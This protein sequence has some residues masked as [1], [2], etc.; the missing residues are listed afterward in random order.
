MFRFLQLPVLVRSISPHKKASGYKLTSSS[1]MC[2]T[3]SCLLQA[4]TV[5][6]VVFQFVSVDIY[7]GIGTIQSAGYNQ[8]CRVSVKFG[9]SATS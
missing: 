3:F 5:F 2:V 7:K 4:A 9:A 1:R 8:I 6:E